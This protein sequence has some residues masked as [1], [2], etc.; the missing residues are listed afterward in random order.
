MNFFFGFKSKNFYSELTIPKFQ[1]SGNLKKNLKLYSAEIK[2]CRWAISEVKSKEDDNFFYLNQKI[3][4]NHSIFFLASESELINYKKVNNKELLD[5]NKFTNT[6]PEYRANFKIY[7]NKGGYSSYQSD[8]PFSMTKV[9]GNILSSTFL[10][11]NK[12]ADKNFVIIR[13]I[14]FKPIVENFDVFILDIEK[15]KILK[16]MIIKTNTTNV[17]ELTREFIKK[18]CYLFSKKFI[19]IP[20]YV[21]VKNNHISMEH[22]LPPTSYIMTGDRYKKVSEIKKKINEITN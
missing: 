14:F 16:K 3:I 8:Y 20:V 12:N 15:K 1:N 17:I 7:N 18:N 2:K 4:N 5:L 22:T 13:N 6:T 21:S 9:N 11:T 19:G 10:L